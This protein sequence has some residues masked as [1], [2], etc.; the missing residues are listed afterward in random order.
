MFSGPVCTRTHPW[1]LS[2]PNQCPIYNSNNTGKPASLSECCLNLTLVLPIWPTNT[3]AG[4]LSQCMY[5]ASTV[6]NNG[7]LPDRRLQCWLHRIQA[8]DTVSHQEYCKL[9]HDQTLWSLPSATK[10]VVESQE[11]NDCEECSLRHSYQVC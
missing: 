2:Q 3:S 8:Q 1:L 5:N 6:I 7:T 4:Q 9:E 11:V 10:F